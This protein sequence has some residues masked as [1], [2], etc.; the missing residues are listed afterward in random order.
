MLT[1]IRDGGW[2]MLFILLFGL[3]GL[4]AG[5]RAVA[6]PDRRRLGLVK[7]LCVVLAASALTGMCACL[8][9]VFH[10]IPMQ[11]LEEHPPAELVDKWHLVTLLGIGESLSPGIMGFAFTAMTA[12]LGAVAASRLPPEEA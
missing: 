11:M 7:G 4:A 10:K 9:T 8:A 1:L 5:A 3:V 6:R 2:P 12:L